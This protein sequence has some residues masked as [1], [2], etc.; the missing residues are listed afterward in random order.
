MS[1][2]DIDKLI[3]SEAKLE[4]IDKHKPTTAPTCTSGTPFLNKNMTD[5]KNKQSTKPNIMSTFLIARTVL[6][7]S[8]VPTDVILN[9]QYLR[10]QQQYKVRYEPS[11]FVKKSNLKRQV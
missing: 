2:V 4:W 3:R 6:D 5:H 9:S 8:L 10:H 11:T 1:F 7:Y